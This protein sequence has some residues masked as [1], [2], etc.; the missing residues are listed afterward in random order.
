MSSF[1]AGHGNA[2]V[3]TTTIVRSQN[4]ALC[5]AFDVP[6]DFFHLVSLNEIEFVLLQLNL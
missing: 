4:N 6:R 2:S 5:F 1:G 3:S